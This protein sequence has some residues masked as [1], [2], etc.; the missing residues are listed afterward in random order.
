MKVDR[1]LKNKS[2]IYKITNIITKQV[3][4]G[5]TKCLVNRSYHYNSAF[6]QKRH[7]QINDYLF[8][9]MTKYGFENFIIEPLEFYDITELAEKELAWITVLKSNNRWYGYNLRLD[10]STGMITSAE[11]SAKIK[12]NITK[13]W[14]NGIRDGHSE[15]LKS[16]WQRDPERLV[17]MSTY[18]S[19]LLTKYNYIVSN[20][21]IFEICDY[22]RLEELKLKY[23]LAKFWKHNTEIVSFKN[24]RIQRISL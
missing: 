21:E 2:C 4:V 14:A 6:K 8:N 1:S 24:Y 22:K 20:T 11:T 16:A 15:K 7:N 13:Q 18:F 9:A 23:V 10:S 12:E 3:Y 17:S 19:K 5:K